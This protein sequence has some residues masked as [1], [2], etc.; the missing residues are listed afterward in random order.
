[1]SEHL[2]IAVVVITLFSAITFILKTLIEGVSRT[3]VARAQTEVMTKMIDRFGSS[4]ELVA[5]LQSEAGK[6]FIETVPEGKTRPH[7]RILNS[8]QGGAVLTVLGAGVMATQSFAGGSEGRDVAMGIGL[9]IM[10]LGVGLLVSAAAAWYMSRSWG[11]LNG[12]SQ[13]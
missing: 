11:L 1:M 2:T 8:V 4:Q 6:R 13:Q 10:T 12:P 7:Q 9:M 3:K 5:Y